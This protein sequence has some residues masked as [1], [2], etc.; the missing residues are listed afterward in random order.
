VKRDKAPTASYVPLLVQR[1]GR[2]EHAAA[3]TPLGSA[4][5]AA[6]L[7][8]GITGAGSGPYSGTPFLPTADAAG[9]Q[10]RTTAAGEVSEAARHDHGIIDHRRHVSSIGRR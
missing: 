3:R 7:A 5:A 1:C 8:Q 9:D 2:R 4:A 10:P 6:A